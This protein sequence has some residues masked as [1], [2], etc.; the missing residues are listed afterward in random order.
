VAVLAERRR[1]RL[2]RSGL[3]GVLSRNQLSAHSSLAAMRTPRGKYIHYSELEGTGELYDL[4]ADRY[5]MK[6]FIGDA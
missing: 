1:E 2:A 5:E 6:N 3:V 4:R